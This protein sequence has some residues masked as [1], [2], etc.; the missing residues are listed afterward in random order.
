MKLNILLFVSLI[1]FS[2]AEKSKPKVLI[3]G[4]SI[5]L[6]YTPYVQEILQD[7]ATVVHHKG[8][9]QYTGNGLLKID[10]W[11][12]DDHWDVI[13][14]NFGLWDLYGWQ[15]MDTLRTPE[16]YG[17]N[18]DVLITRLEQTGAEIIWAT[19]TPVCP[20]PERTCNLVIDKKTEKR[21][22][23]AAL[24]VMRK[25]SIEVNDLYKCI[26]PFMNDHSLG[27]NNVHFTKNGYRILAA[28]VSE[29]IQSKLNK[30]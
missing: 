26:H 5:S 13:H 1:L 10:K 7:E 16:T 29:S 27:K 8:N 11:L 18:L 12:G 22:R 23:R 6:G 20:G 28:Q 24:K 21:F 17:A 3:I 19:T 25:H 9:A 2:S 4:D 30:K 15:Y 14:V